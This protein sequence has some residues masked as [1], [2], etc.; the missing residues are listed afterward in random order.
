MELRH[1]RYFRAVAELLNFS[2]A[3]ESQHVAQPALSRQIRALEDEIGIT[4]LD[5]NHVRVRLTDAGRTF[6]AHTCKILAQVDMAVAAVQEVSEGSA[7][8]LIICNDWHLGGHLVPASL[9]EFRASH[10]RAEVI[11]HDR[12]L[13]DQLALI[14]SRRV[15]LGFTVRELLGSR[16]D[17]EYFVM[18]CSRLGIALPVNHP[19][20]KRKHLHLAE[21]ADEAWISIDRKESPQYVNYLNRLCRLSGFTPHLGVTAG[22]LEGTLG[23]IASGYGIALLPEHILQPNTGPVAF[24]SCDCEPIEL[25]AVWH[26]KEK[27][28]L[29][30]QYLEILRAHVARLGQGSPASAPTEP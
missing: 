1:L 18:L 14:S 19:L 20:A 24:V 28:K 29:L 15:H 11:L 10:P 8:E 9:A 22:T 3:A 30:H 21:L 4:L 23:R 12:K 17:L 25:C 16:R 13:H 27:S 7:G 6:Y 2:R 26:R 5:R